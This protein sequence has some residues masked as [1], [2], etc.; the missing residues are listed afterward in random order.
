ML[1]L[2]LKPYIEVDGENFTSQSELLGLKKNRYSSL[3]FKH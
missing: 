2:D 3:N 1:D